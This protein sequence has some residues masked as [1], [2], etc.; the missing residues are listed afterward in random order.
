MRVYEDDLIKYMCNGVSVVGNATSL[1]DREYGLIIDEMPTIRFNWSKIEKGESQGTRWDFL[2]S[3]SRWKR[4]V[5]INMCN[6]SNDVNSKSS[7]PLFHTLLLNPGL[8]NEENTIV[9]NSKNKYDFYFG[10][11][12]IAEPWKRRLGKRIKLS[13]GMHSLILLDYLG[14]ERVRIFGFDGYRS[15]SYYTNEISKSHDYST[16]GIMR[17]ELIE[18][19]SWKV[20]E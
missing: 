13:S 20:Y 15:K 16:E 1:F 9:R 10:E 2:A 12:S 6:K 18:K 14:I 17:K 19:N 4:S 7:I 5:E 3:G 11:L 8:K